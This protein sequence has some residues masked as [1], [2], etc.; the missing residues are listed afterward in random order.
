MANAKIDVNDKP[1]WIAYNET[2]GE[3]E[4]VACDPVTGA[5][6]VHLVTQSVTLPTSLQNAKIDAN[7]NSTQLGYNETTGAIEA[8]RC[9]SS[10]ELL[11]FIA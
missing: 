5:L 10:G 6:Y 9:A 7:E 1:T 11:V 3:V 4:P 8:M 2:T